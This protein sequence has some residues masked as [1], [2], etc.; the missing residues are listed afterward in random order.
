MLNNIKWETFTYSKD[1]IVVVAKFWAKDFSI[2]YDN[3]KYGEFKFGLHL[4]YMIPK[5]YKE[6]DIEKWAD[7]AID[8]FKNAESWLD[9][10]HQDL[11]KFYELEKLN[12]KLNN[13]LLESLRAD[14]R[15]LKLQLT[16]KQIDNK[17]YQKQLKPIKDKITSINNSRSTRIHN[18]LLELTNN[19]YDLYHIVSD[20]YY[21]HFID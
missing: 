8:L 19:N 9:K 20:Y 2:K 17:S 18:K 21:R 1:N 13:E 14:K 12:N 11:N 7:Y 5:T 15:A 6:A 10:Y 3:P 4:M 16:N